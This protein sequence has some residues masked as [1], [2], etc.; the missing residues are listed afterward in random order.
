[1]ASHVGCMHGWRRL[2]RLAYAR[3]AEGEAFDVVSWS[4]VI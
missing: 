3:S 4:R 2:P 1:M